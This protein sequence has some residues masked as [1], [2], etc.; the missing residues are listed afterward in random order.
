MILKL[1]VLKIILITLR[2]AHVSNKMQKMKSFKNNKI[3]KKLSVNIKNLLKI[4]ILILLYAKY[5]ILW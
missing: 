4:W 1:K 5:N 2:K 3:N